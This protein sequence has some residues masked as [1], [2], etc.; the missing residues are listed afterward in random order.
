M[1]RHQVEV[2]DVQ[3]EEELPK[4][5]TMPVPA[6]FNEQL[7]QEILET[8]NKLLSTG[9]F[10]LYARVGRVKVKVKTIYFNAHDR[11]YLDLIP[12]DENDDVRVCALWNTEFTCFVGVR[13]WLW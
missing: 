9:M 8:V 13:N 4:M 3:V 7:T 10:H 2:T 1:T 5:E 12:I 6:V 11:N